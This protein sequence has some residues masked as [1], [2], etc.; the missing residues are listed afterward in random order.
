MRGRA[1]LPRI[2]KDHSSI[3][4]SRS[5]GQEPVGLLAAAGRAL[6]LI[7]AV[8]A[9]GFRVTAAIGAFLDAAVRAQDHIRC[10]LVAAFR[11]AGAGGEKRD[12]S[13]QGERNEEFLHG[14]VG[15]L[16]SKAAA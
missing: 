9:L 8:A 3:R 12:G 11:S 14:I 4:W 13:G 5:S 10:H 15:S 6:D 1:G 7:A 16:G 2:P